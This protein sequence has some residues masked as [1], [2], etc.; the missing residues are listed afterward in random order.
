MR[1]SR[2]RGKV[3]TSDTKDRWMIT[4]A[5]LITLLLIFFVIMYA[6]SRLDADKYKVVTESLQHTFKKGDSVLEMGSGVNGSADKY[7]SKNPPSTTPSAVTKA[8]GSGS[9]LSNNSSNSP[10][11]EREI[12]FRKQESQLQ[13]LM[14]VIQ[15]YIQDNNLQEQI[16]VSDLAKGIT[17]TLSDRFL[18]DAGR[19]DLKAG[20]NQTL[21][22]LASLFT[23][24][25]TVV[26]IEGHSDNQPI[27]RASRYTDNWELSGARALS[28]LRYFLNNPNLDSDK[29]QYAGYADT[30]P[31]A[32]NTT[33]Q[34]RSKNRRVEIT[35]LR[36]LQQ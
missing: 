15:K 25:D 14:R 23:K 4:Y 10:L 27:T 19:A 7:R 32:D 1:N 2:R 24:L 5:D 13:D 22:K 28:V 3:E 30:H 35:V 33:E 12:A 16:R 8:A 17:I 20:S 36:Q 21:S 29:F 31:T 11:S 34:G 9:T 26:S 6:M 18:F